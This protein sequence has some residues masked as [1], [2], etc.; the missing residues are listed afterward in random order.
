MK[1]IF[2][3]APGAGK[4]TVASR[5]Q[6]KYN[7][8]H[9]STGD[10]FREAIKQETELGKKAKSF[11]DAGT[12][13]PDEVTTGMLKERINQADCKQ[14]FILDGFPRTIVQAEALDNEG[15]IIDKA[16]NF[17]VSEKTVVERI[18]NRW[19]CKVDGSIYN[20][21]TL[22]PQV[23]GKCDKCNGELFQRDDQKPEVV[24]KRMAVY[25]EQTTP[26]I[27]F[28]KEK[29]ILIEVD[30]ESPVDEVFESVVSVLG[31]RL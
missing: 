15:I 30:A 16:V 12:L 3:G 9:I 14:G 29:G 20:T 31:L 1:L 25:Q 18:S 4:G 17:I 2:L 27:D 21:L 6:E 23:E 11:M 13:V 10:M 5:I 28:Y 22:P 19:T 24:K 7:L 8:S 26:L